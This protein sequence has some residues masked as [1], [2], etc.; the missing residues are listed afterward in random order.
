MND[1]PWDITF[2]VFS[3]LCFTTYLIVTILMMND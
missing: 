1:F 2:M 3:L